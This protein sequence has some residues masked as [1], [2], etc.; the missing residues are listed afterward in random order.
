[1]SSNKRILIAS[2]RVEKLSSLC[3]TNLGLGNEALV[4]GDLDFKIVTGTTHLNDNT[5]DAIGNLSRSIDAI[6]TR[7]QGTVA[8]FEESREIVKALIAETVDITKNIQRGNTRVR[9]DESRYE[10]GFRELIAGINRNLDAFGK[11]ITEITD[12][13]DGLSRK[14]LSKM[15]SGDYEGDFDAIKASVN[16]AVENLDAGF[17]QILASTEQISSA[18]SEIGAGSQTLAQ[19]ASE[20]ASSIEEIS[21]SLQEI[22]SMAE[23]NTEYSREASNLSGQARITAE[24]GLESMTKLSNAIAEIKKSSD[25]TAKIVKTIEEIAFQTNLLALNAAVEAAR[26]GD[27]GKGFA[28]VAEE[29][30]NLAMRSAEAAKSTSEIIDDSVSNTY[31]GVDLNDNV[32]QDLE[33]I[34]TQILRVNEVIKEVATASEQQSQGVVQ[35]NRAIEQMNTVTQQAAAN[36]EESASAAE[37]LAGQASEMLNVVG[38]YKLSGNNNTFVPRLDRS[39]SDFAPMF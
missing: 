3:I 39:H 17:K 9:G 8:K 11:P 21:G 22:S 27:A 13:V 12:V 2:E 34:N 18:A 6:I 33:E 14:D 24:R 38:A 29:V 37:E 4:H 7:T 36:S 5:P 28:V 30:R 10:G 1:M 19:G 23:R 16:T 25:A 31:L 20:Q 32:R 26:A 35:I 15:M